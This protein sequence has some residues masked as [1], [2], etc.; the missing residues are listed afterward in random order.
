MESLSTDNVKELPKTE[1]IKYAGSKLKLLP[2]ILSLINKQPNIKTV[3]DAFSGTTRV[4]QALAKS[5]YQVISTDISVWSEIFGKCYLLNKKSINEYKELINYLNSVKPHDGWF[6]ENYGGDSNEGSSIQSDGLKKPW[7]KHNTQKLDGIREEI[8]KLNLNDIDK[9]IALTSLILA[10]DKVDNTLGHQASYLQK[11]SSRSYNLMQLKVPLLFENE[12]DNTV[13]RGNIFDFISSIKSDLVYLDPPYGSSN[14]KMPAS[15]V[16][17]ASYYHI[18]TSICLYDKPELFGKAKRRTD[19]SDG[20]SSSIFEEF[21]KNKNNRFIAIE[22]IEKLIRDINAEWIILSYNTE[23]RATA[24]DLIDILSSNGKII[25]IINI[26]YKRNVMAS[27]KWT[28]EWIKDTD[29]PN[30]EILFLMKK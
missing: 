12:L 1:G 19:T 15:R 17:Y 20:I 30:K 26:D 21:R 7:Q 13:L 23:G 11:W 6:T 22:A 10:M 9:S 18:W 3:W 25:D 27:M 5:K 14:E 28:N 4:S 16:R 8:E 24:N 2:C 29:K